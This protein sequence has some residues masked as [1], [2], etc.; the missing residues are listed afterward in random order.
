MSGEGGRQRWRKRQ[1]PE[2]KRRNKGRMELEKLP[3]TTAATKK[4]VMK[5]IAEGHT[6]KIYASFIGSSF[7]FRDCT[8]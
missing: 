4:K 3:A 2:E 1:M 8:Y 5:K 6:E 7:S